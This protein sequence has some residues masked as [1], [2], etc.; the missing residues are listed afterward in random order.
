MTERT[1]Q[2]E[3]ARARWGSLS[4]ERVLRAAI[5]LADAGG[6]EA[7]SIDRLA[8]ELGAEP[9]SLYGSVRLE[10]R[11]AAGHARRRL[12]RDGAARER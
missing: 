10:G 9:M 5:E 8:Q 3:R 1:R 7:L 11:A 6:I 2:A 12:R 4:R